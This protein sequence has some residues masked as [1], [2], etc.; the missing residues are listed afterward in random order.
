MSLNR[1]EMLRLGAA[2]AG[3]LLISSAASSV[4]LPAGILTAP[5]VT[6]PTPVPAAPVAPT[7]P[8]GIDPVLFQKAKAALDS[9]PWIGKRDFIGIV[10]FTKASADPRFHVG[11][12]AFGLSRP[13]LE[14]PRLGGDVERRLYDG[15][16]LSRQVRAFDEGSRSRLDEQ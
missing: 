7:A 16:D 15:R 12:G 6:P 11:P 5:P 10:D 8:A 2:G 3:G 14:P 4:P 13:F 9:R 1:R